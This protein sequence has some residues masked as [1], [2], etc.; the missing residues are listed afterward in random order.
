MG[1]RIRSLWWLCIVLA[2]CT[3]RAPRSDRESFAAPSVATSPVADLEAWARARVHRACFSFT[4]DGVPSGW[5]IEDWSI[6]ERASVP[7]LVIYNELF[8][9]ATSMGERMESL[10]CST[11]VYD[12]T[13][14]GELAEFRETLMEDGAEQR[15]VLRREGELWRVHRDD[16][17]GSVER[18]GSFSEVG[19]VLASIRGLFD[20][21]DAGPEPAAHVTFKR[22][23]LFTPRVISDVECIYEERLDDPDGAKHRVTIVEAGVASENRLDERG[24]QIDGNVADTLAM[25]RVPEAEARALSD[26]MA[27]LDGLSRVPVDFDL[28]DG[29]RLSRLVVELSGLGGATLPVCARQRNL[30]TGD[31]RIVIETSRTAREPAELLSAEDR[32]RYVACDHRVS[33]DDPGVRR[34]AERVVA[35][36]AGGRARI[37]A[38]VK[39][40]DVLLDDTGAANASDAATILLHRRGDCTEHTLLFV[41][42]ARAVGLPAREVGGLVWCGPGSKAFGWHAWAEVHDGERWIQVDPTFG[43]FP[44]DATHVMTQRDSGATNDAG[45]LPTLAIRLVRSE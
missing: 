33:C 41:A 14:D 42:M 20:W 10:L 43:Q 39:A 9:R 19:G 30:L 23:S 29:A 15:R 7:C 27:S 38:L 16:A 35:G 45:V 34:E 6:A 4:L 3:T 18:E 40:V 25:R 28:G 5:Y 32:A 13:R 44:A 1:V 37:R 12:V 2:A 24:I 26:V 11:G 8:M 36:H 21:L 22:L 17:E 31:D